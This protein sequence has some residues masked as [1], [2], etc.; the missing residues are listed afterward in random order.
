MECLCLKHLYNIKT[1]STILFHKRFMFVKLIWFILIVLKYMCYFFQDGPIGPNGPSARLHAGDQAIVRE[2]VRAGTQK[3][4][5]LKLDVSE[6][7]Q[8]L[9]PYALPLHAKVE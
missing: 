8:K 2:L 5:L 6:I 4:V 3:L 7:C 9:I 1:S